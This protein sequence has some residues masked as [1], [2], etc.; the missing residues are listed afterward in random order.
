[1]I[2]KHYRFLLGGLILLLFCIGPSIAETSTVYWSPWVTKANSTSATINWKGDVNES[3]VIEYAA[4]SN[5]TVHHTYDTTLSS[6]LSTP[7]QHVP[8]TGLAPNTSYTY[9]VRPSRHPDTFGPRTFRTMPVSGPF[10]FIVISDSQEGANYTEWMRFKYVADAVAQEP[11]VV[12]I[13]HGGDFAGHDSED[14]WSTYFQVA[15]GML[16]KSA[17]VSNIGNHEYHNSSGESNPPTNAF[18]YHLSYDTALNYSFDCAGVRFIILNSPDPDATNNDDDPHTSYALAESQ[19]PWLQDQLRTSLLGV[20]T[21]HH[22]PIWEYGT[23]TPNPN[24]TPWESL[25]HTYGISANFA[26]HIHN[27]Q[28]YSIDGIP[29]FIVGNAGGR[30][31]NITEGDP[32]PAG[33]QFGRTRVLGYLKV[34]VDPEN[35]TATAQEIFVAS[36][37]ENDDNETPSVYD[38]PIIADTV[39]FPL[40]ISAAHTNPAGDPVASP[41]E[42]PGHVYSPGF[43]W[44][45]NHRP[46]LFS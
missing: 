44:D 27:Y 42:F 15:D 8:L 22:H 6:D 9:L 12:F 18:Q 2:E 26:G 20:F 35:N 29:Y 34:T 39:T 23:P 40:K 21:M 30:C 41:F 10:T 45:T 33:F 24:L 32:Y 5:F 7:Y 25:Y 11:D 28:R 19:E 4:T 36:V 17:I 13:L 31:N 14:L 1:M 16:A 43:W 3:G 37:T 38:S 46:G